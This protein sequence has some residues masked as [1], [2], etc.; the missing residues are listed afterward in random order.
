MFSQYVA[1]S[2]NNKH[3]KKDINNEKNVDQGT[4]NPRRRLQA[5]MVIPSPSANGEYHVNWNKFHYVKD[6]SWT[7]WFIGPIM[8]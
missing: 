4:R 6:E 3:S 8:V 2:S 5:S 7:H 1:T